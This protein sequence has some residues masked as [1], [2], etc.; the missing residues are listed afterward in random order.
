MF[1]YL[2]YLF[3]CFVYYLVMAVDKGQESSLMALAPDP[4]CYSN[5]GLGL[6]GVLIW[7][8]VRGSIDMGWYVKLT[9]I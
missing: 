2:V 8:R 5:G 7:V 9:N 3:T 4:W 6:G 1:I